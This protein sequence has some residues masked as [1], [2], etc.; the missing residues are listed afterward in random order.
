MFKHYYYRGHMNA[1]FG[2]RISLSV[3]L[4]LITSHLGVRAQSSGTSTP[5][6]AAASKAPIDSRWDLNIVGGSLL[7]QDGENVQ[8]NLANIIDYLRDSF[9]ANIVLAPGVGQV[10]VGDLKLASFQW[11]PAL[12]ALKV[13]S[14]NAFVWKRRSDP[15]A[16]GA[17]DPTTGLPAL[18]N[19]ALSG[20]SDGREGL[21]MLTLDDSGEVPGPRRV[22]EVFN[23]GGYLR[24]QDKDK[25]DKSLS[26]ITRFIDETLSDF[27]R[28]QDRHSSL[29]FKFH[30][31]AS[32]LV[33]SG[34]PGEVEVARKVI[35]ALPET[36]SSKT[37]SLGPDDAARAA[38]LRRYGLNPP[39]PEPQ[40][41]EV[42]PSSTP[43][44]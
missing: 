32:L 8:A 31:G 1:G 27:D 41:G 40:A 2:C 25:Q 37:Q 4:L 17:V 28:G 7:R 9:P 23:L 15:S 29:R 22:V 43:K 44:R 34:S 3:L 35:L 39:Q 12:D 21:L 36:S 14:G 13:A 19:A 11:E 10:M 18:A 42:A 16:V 5:A 38:F 26:E 30:S 20:E 33:V 24:G 6:S